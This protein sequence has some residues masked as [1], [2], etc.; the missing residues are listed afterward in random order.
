MSFLFCKKKK[1]P[2]QSV[3]YEVTRLSEVNSK[4][5]YLLL[6][7]DWDQGLPFYPETNACANTCV[8]MS[9]FYRWKMLA[10]VLIDY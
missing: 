6:A 1:R 10:S 5:P 3:V 8:I 2:T 7:M 4:H 9:L